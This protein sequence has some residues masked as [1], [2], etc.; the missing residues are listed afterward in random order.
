MSIEIVSFEPLPTAEFSEPAP[1]RLLAGRPRQEIRNVYADPER[2]FFVGH[3]RATPGKWRVAYT[4]HEFC[5]LLAGR[6]RIV[7]TDGMMREFGPGE[8]FVV[9]AGFK[10]TWEVIET[11]TKLYAIYESA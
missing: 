9:P 6:V 11:A 5:H 4:E 10:G 7:S 8:S 1:D 3:W 2:R